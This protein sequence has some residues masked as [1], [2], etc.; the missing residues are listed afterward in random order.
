M[1]ILIPLLKKQI[2]VGRCVL[3]WS[4]KVIELPE[5]TKKYKEGQILFGEKV[6]LPIRFKEN[7]LKFEADV[8]FGQ[9][10]GKNN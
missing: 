2:P 6:E 1:D 7:G 5:T 9:K 10:T 4:R 3:R 8:I